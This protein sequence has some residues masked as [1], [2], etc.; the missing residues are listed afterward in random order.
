M[1]IEKNIQDTKCEY[2]NEL[3]SYG[4]LSICEKE[5]ECPY[6]KIKIYPNFCPV[7]EI[8]EFQKEMEKINRENRLAGGG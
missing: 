5:G 8:S 7:I 6:G 3:E 4:G 2:L 1:T